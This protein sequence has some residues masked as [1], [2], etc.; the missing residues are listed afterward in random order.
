VRELGAR[1]AGAVLVEVAGD[2]VVAAVGARGRRDVVV[3]ALLG[4][5]QRGVVIVADAVRKV[6]G[7]AGDIGV[8]RPA[9]RASAGA[10]VC[11]VGTHRYWERR[12][13]GMNRGQTTEMG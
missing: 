2:E 11:V 3:L 13:E 6:R 1:R 5:A 4:D 9:R 8:E 7:G 10:V 12:S